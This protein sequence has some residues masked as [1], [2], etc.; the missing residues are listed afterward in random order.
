MSVPF[1]CLACGYREERPF[2]VGQICPACG[3]VRLIAY[4]EPLTR[5]FIHKNQR[6]L[7]M[8]TR[9]EDGRAIR[10]DPKVK[11][12]KIIYLGLY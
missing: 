2:T 9:L 11:P 8:D 3:R 4:Q 1:I 5:T 12:K 7:R 6:L 10:L